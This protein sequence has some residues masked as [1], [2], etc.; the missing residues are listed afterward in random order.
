M[1]LFPKG[2]VHLIVFFSYAVQLTTVVD[3]IVKVATG[4]YAIVV[5]FVVFFNV[6]VN[7]TIAFISESIVEDFLY[8][9]F[10]FDDVACGMWFNA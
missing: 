5:F 9:L 6:K 4:E 10:L 3:N 7:R 8:E 1:S 2:K